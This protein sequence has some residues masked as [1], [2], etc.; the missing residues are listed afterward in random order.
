MGDLAE[1]L[2]KG[3]NIF[4]GKDANMQRGDYITQEWLAFIRA[5]SPPS[6]SSDKLALIDK[7]LDFSKSA[8]A[9]IKSEWYQLAIKVGYT[10]VRPEIEKHLTLVGRRWLIQGIYQELKDSKRAD[11]LEWAKDIFEKVKG[12]YHF[13]SRS[14]VKEILYS[15]EK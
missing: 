8:N 11:D 15:E 3:E 4:V 13:I 1:K 10:E 12:N 14:T 7:Q 6:L 2:N 5:L 9:V